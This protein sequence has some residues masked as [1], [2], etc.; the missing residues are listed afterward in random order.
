VI[1][2]ILLWSALLV[3][4]AAALILWRQ[5]RQAP[6]VSVG[7]VAWLASA[8]VVGS[9]EMN[10]ADLFLEEHPGSRIRVLPLDDEWQA[11]R[12][13]PVIREAIGRGVRFFVSTHPSRCAV[14][15]MHLFADSQA[16][17]ITT[18]STSPALTGKDDSILRIIPDAE[19]EQRAIARQVS[20][21]PGS[22][23][24]VLQD[25]GNLAYTDPAFAAFATELEVLGQW[26]IV[27]RTLMV[28]DFKPDEYRALMAEAFDA[29]Y[30]LAGTFQTPIGNIAQLFHYLHPQ[31]PILLTP[32]ARSPAI[33]E[34]AG[35]AIDRIILPSPY[36]SRHQ[37]SALDDYLRRY[38]AR[39]GY[40]AHAMTIGVRQALEL[41]DEAFAQG[42][43]DPAQVKRYLLSVPVHQTSLGPVAFDLTGD[44][45][46]TFHF[47][48]DPKQELP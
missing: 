29:L 21:W 2:K 12:S 13:V 24:L 14:A 45:T 8:A 26:R 20:Q 4:V 41:L 10:A 40:E 37:D 19:Q 23:L 35:D 39:F 44:V 25:A 16:L 42:Y 48:T 34:T 3:M 33:L 15:S 46:G 43:S 11:Q 31:A 38:R 32:W 30:I 47:L 5:V 7:V 6:P 9:S 28:S 18:A 36:P 17:M 27:H 1:K 22:R